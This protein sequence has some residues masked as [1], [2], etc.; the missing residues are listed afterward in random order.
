MVYKLANVQEYPYH[1]AFS[2][3]QIAVTPNDSILALHDLFSWIVSVSS[4]G[5]PLLLSTQEKNRQSISPHFPHY[6]SPFVP[7]QRHSTM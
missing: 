6:R 3:T 1:K 7:M 2:H 5:V 4:L